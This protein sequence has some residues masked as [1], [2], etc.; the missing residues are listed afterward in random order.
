MENHATLAV[1]IKKLSAPL[2]REQEN[3]RVVRN[4]S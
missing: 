1:A 3:E 2:V 4:S